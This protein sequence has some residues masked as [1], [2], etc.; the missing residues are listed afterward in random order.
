MQYQLLYLQKYKLVLLSIKA[1]NISY[2]TPLLLRLR[3][4]RRRS[5]Q[6]FCPRYIAK[7]FRNRRLIELN[8]AGIIKNTNESTSDFRRLI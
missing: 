8:Y 5:K 6:T 1:S 4:S 7:R 3:R 2:K